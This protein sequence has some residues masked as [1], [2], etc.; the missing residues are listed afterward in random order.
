MIL[1]HFT[2]SP[3]ETADC[4]ARKGSG[5]GTKF[6]ETLLQV[7]HLENGLGFGSR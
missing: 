1:V 5:R 6:G 3:K 7:R 2:V 4:L